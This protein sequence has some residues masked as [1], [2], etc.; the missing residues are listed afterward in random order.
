MNVRKIVSKKVISLQ[1]YLV[2]WPSGL[3]IGL[4]NRVRRFESARNL[5]ENQRNK[6][7]FCSFILYNKGFMENI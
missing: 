5:N 6:T 7:M 2:P 3:G 4:Q 1:H